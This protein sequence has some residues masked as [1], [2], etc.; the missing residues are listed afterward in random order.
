L[1]P[2]LCRAASS[3]PRMAW[4]ASP[5]LLLPSPDGALARGFWLCCGAHLQVNVTNLLFGVIPPAQCGYVDCASQGLRACKR[6]ASGLLGVLECITVDDATNMDCS[7]QKL[8]CC[9][10]NNRTCL[11]AGT[12]TRVHR[13]THLKTHLA[14]LDLAR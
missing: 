2:N 11:C 12:K 14:Q 9:C 1:S 13:A 8:R 5:S 10:A 6:G 3:D 4:F 7:E